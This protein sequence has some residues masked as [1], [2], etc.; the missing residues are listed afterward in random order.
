[1]PEYCGILFDKDGTLFD[2]TDS[3]AGWAARLIDDLAGG[4]AARAAL[5]GALVGFDRETGV[6]AADSM[7]IA[8]TPDD[9]AGALLPHL[10]GWSRR[11]IVDH[12][13]A[14]AESVPMTSPVALVPLIEGLRRDGFRLG[15]ATND[16]AAPAQ[17]HMERAGIRH[18][19]DFI[20]GSDSGFGA[21]PAPGMQLAFCRA[22]GLAPAQVVMVGDSVADMVAGRAAGMATVAVLSGPA[23]E[24][25]LVPHADAVLPDIGALPSW[26]AEQGRG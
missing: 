17:A 1:M 4:D 6:F 15:V 26:L 18:L 11:R 22:T 13:N 16:G 2:F 19:L 8:G 7:I 14:L 9:I 10:E 20:A 3:W 21:K 23:G 12:A 5:I 25:E 24:G